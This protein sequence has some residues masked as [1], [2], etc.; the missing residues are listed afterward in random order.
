MKSVLQPR[1]ALVGLLLSG[2]ALAADYAW[3]WPLELPNDGNTL[4]HLQLNEAVYQASIDPLL[5]DVE[6]VDAVGNPLPAMLQAPVASR[7]VS[8]ESF[9]AVWFP[10]AK[11]PSGGAAGW[12]A[13]IEGERVTLEGHLPEPAV[14]L[15]DAGVTELL[16]DL[17]EHADDVRAL[18][19]QLAD[20]L[21]AWQTVVRLQGSRQLEVWTELRAPVRL[22]RLSHQGEW[23][24]KTH[25]E[26]SPSVGR[27]L[28]LTFS[29]PIDPALIHAIRA[30]RR[31][32]E[33]ELPPLHWISLQGTRQ[34]D[35]SWTFELPGAMP[36][37]GFD[38]QVPGD[39]W[40]VKLDLQSRPW[41]D[42]SWVQRAQGTHYR[43][44]VDGDWLAGGEQ[45]FAVTRDRQW[46]LRTDQP[47][48]ASPQLK[49][50]YHPDVLVFASKGVA[51]AR[52]LAG[53]R[54]GRRIDAPLGTALAAVRGR[55][56]EHW[57]APRIELG[58]RSERAGSAAL[59]QGISPNR[60]LKLALW[61]LLVVAALS[62]L[63]IASKLLREGKAPSA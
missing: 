11:A 52:L 28:R 26:W 25:I 23:L 31:N 43:V 63:L 24:R 5:R 9:D 61:G 7:S 44:Q 1:A 2:S 50:A 29:E 6:I 37:Q 59:E 45:S 33:F 56:G 4:F 30:T 42:A 39:Q 32:T 36:I 62:L 22:Y 35:G 16:V 18:D 60:W 49:L 57:Q 58:P 27:Y 47:L 51:E 17:G 14:A 48:G 3:Q 55:R 46:R 53:S 12:R 40:L 8:S 20:E 13:V 10:L 41:A 38:L 19:L 54:V 21:S 34:D 15:P